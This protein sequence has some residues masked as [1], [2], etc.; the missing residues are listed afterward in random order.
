MPVSWPALCPKHAIAL[1]VV[2]ESTPRISGPSCTVVDNVGEG[3]WHLV[4][5]FG[6]FEIPDL[7]RALLNARGLDAAIDFDKAMFVGTRDLIMHKREG[8]DL[9]RRLATGLVC[10]SLPKRSKGGRSIQS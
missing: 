3:L 10:A 9:L 1:S 7:R 6:F 2:F 4:A 8:C 5:R